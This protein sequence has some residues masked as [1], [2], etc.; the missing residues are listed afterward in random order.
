ML[1]ACRRSKQDLGGLTFLGANS[2]VHV[3]KVSAQVVPAALPVVDSASAVAE[4]LVASDPVIGA[5][6]KGDRLRVGLIIKGCAS[7]FVRPRPRALI[8]AC[9]PFF[10]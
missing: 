2:T 10:L 3:V 9:Q 8:Y 7:I 6:N 4:E 5:T 1:G